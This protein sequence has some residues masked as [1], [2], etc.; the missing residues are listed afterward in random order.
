MENKYY[1]F[2]SKGLLTTLSATPKLFKEAIQ[3]N[4]WSENSDRNIIPR[5]MFGEYPQDIQFPVEF[6][7]QDG[8]L[9][10]NILEIRYPSAFLVSRHLADIFK[11]NDITGWKSYDICIEKKNGEQIDGFCGFSVIGRNQRINN[12][13]EAI[14]DFFRL[15]D[16]WLWI[17][18]SQKVVDVLCRNKIMDFTTELITKDNHHLFDPIVFPK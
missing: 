13:S 3:K 12:N 4:D 11:S 6:I 7:V 1:A 10:R 9:L 18:C 16:E 17:I 15:H 5:L 14:P 2:D 8:R